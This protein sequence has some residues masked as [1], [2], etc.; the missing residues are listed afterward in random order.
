MYELPQVQGI[1]DSL[2]EELMYA[3]IDTVSVNNG[4]RLEEIKGAGT[5]KIIDIMRRGR[6]ILIQLSRDSFLLNLEEDNGLMLIPEKKR[7]R[8]TI[9]VFEMSIGYLYLTGDKREDSLVFVQKDKTEIPP[10]GV[11]PL[12]KQFNFKYLYKELSKSQKSLQAFLTDQ[13]IIAGIGKTYASR[14]LK[15]S[16]LKAKAEC[17]TISKARAKTLFWSI[18]SVLREA[19]GQDSEADSRNRRPQK[20]LHTA[21]A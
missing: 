10:V 14:I 19:L 13:T 1:V 12:T 5:Q 7:V 18:K 8:K 21:H 9:A 3:Y 16:D 20:S 4:R 15:D 11:D 17:K 6:Y 2:R